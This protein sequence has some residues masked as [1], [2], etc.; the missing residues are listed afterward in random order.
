[1]DAYYSLLKNIAY[2]V[3]KE[4]APEGQNTHYVLIRAEG[5]TDG[6]NKRSFVDEAVVVIDIVTVF[7]NNIDRSVVETIDGIVRGLILPTPFR[8][9]LTAPSGF[10]FLNVTREQSA[11][12]PEEEGVKKYYR[13]VSR[14]SQRIHLTN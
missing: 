3:F 5:E 7:K 11:Y 14:Y 8:S 2:D 12:F 9:G 13:K 1:M 10:Q 4:D 6:S